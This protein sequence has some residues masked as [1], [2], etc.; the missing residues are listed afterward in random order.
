MRLPASMVH[1]FDKIDD[2]ASEGRTRN[3][4]LEEAILRWL[5]ATEAKYRQEYGKDSSPGD[6]GVPGSDG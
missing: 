1:E 5:D 6:S 3:D 2:W 4:F